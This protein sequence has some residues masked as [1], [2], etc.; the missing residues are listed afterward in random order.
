MSEKLNSGVKVKVAPKTLVNKVNNNVMLLKN[1]KQRKISMMKKTSKFP[2][3]TAI[4]SLI[5]FLPLSL[6]QLSIALEICLKREDKT[7]GLPQ[8]ML[9]K[10]LRTFHFFRLNSLL[11]KRTYR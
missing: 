6:I 7:K 4:V 11:R 5:L 8:G 2:T 3:K 10:C 1:Q 9:N